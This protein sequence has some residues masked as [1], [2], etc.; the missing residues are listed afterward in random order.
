MCR[1]LRAGMIAGY[2]TMYKAIAVC[3]ECG[4]AMRHT[5][6]TKIFVITNYCPT[7]IVKS[8]W[9]S[10]SAAACI[11]FYIR[12]VVEKVTL[13]ITYRACCDNRS[14]RYDSSC[15]SRCAARVERVIWTSTR[16]KTQWW[17]NSAQ[18]ETDT[19]LWEGPVSTVEAMVCSANKQ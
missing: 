8:P 10:L 11:H 16:C 18:T 14:H 13:Q 15:S 1:S 12:R 19:I 17:T 5:K 2:C 6:C 3:Q 9:H 4:E 7:V